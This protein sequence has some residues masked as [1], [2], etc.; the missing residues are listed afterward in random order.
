MPA[1]EKFAAD[2]LKPS[3]QRTLQPD[4]CTSHRP[5]DANQMASTQM[6]DQYRS[7]RSA[8]TGG[9]AARTPEV[10][11]MQTQAGE[12]ACRVVFAGATVEPG[13]SETAPSEAA[14]Q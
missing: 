1:A 10:G 11:D 5:R 9:G 13:S 8:T 12:A 2:G 7:R 14:S 3:G 6:Q 4:N